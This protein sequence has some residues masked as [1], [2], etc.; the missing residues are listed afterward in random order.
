M[1][2]VV[3]TVFIYLLIGTCLEPSFEKYVQNRIPELNITNTMV[4]EMILLWPEYII[5]LF[6]GRK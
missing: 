5:L 6:N 3:A 4:F 1:G 2:T